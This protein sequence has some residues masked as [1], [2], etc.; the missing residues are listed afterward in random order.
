MKQSNELSLKQSVGNRR[1]VKG[2]QRTKAKLQLSSHWTSVAAKVMTYL[3]LI[4]IS[5]VFL[6]PLLNMISM[7]FMSTS[8][9]INPE[10]DWIPQ[11]PTIHNF[12]VASMVL[13]LPKTL[14]NS[15][16]VSGL[17]ALAQTLVSTL[18]AFAFARYKFPLKNIFFAFMLLSFIIPL[19]VVLIPR[20]MIFTT[21]QNSAGI[22]LIGTAIPQFVM[23]ALGQGVYSAILILICY[24]F[25]KNIP[26]SLDEAAKIDGASP[27]QVFWHITIKLSM[28][29]I[30]TVFLFSFVWNWNETQVTATFMRTGIDLLPQRLMNF[31]SVFSQRGADLPGPGGGEARINEAYKMAGTLISIL[32]LLVL[33]FFTQRQFI[34]G[35]ENTGIK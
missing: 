5:Y 10:V 14:I 4:S 21:I 19:P 32:P 2:L 15:T 29:I 8:D 6:Y 13:L 23:A 9:L 25:F 16:L 12:R 20:L 22:Q 30:I 18:T 34:E 28:T 1:V 27:K 11:H 33:Y 7:S 17:F 24:N 35:I 3:I 26:L 31:D